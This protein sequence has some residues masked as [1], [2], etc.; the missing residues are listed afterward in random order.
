MSRFNIHRITP[1]LV[2]IRLMTLA[3]I[4]TTG[5]TLASTAD[6]R[7]FE[8]LQGPFASGPEVTKACISCHNKAAGEVQDSIH[9]SWEFNHPVTGQ[10]LGKRTVINS[11]C[12]NVVSN[13]PRCTSCH[14]SYDWRDM[15]QDPPSA[16]DDSKV[17]C[18]VCHD[19]TGD[20]SKWPTG[21]GHPLYKET[22]QKGKTYLPPDLTQVAQNVGMPGRENCGACHFYGGGG[23]NVKHGDLSSALVEATADVDIHMNKDG[24][25]FSCSTCHVA[26]DHKW[27]GSHYSMMATDPEGTGKPGERRNSASCESCHGLE[28]HPKTSIN[29]LKLNHHVES[30]AC[31]TCHIP[32]FAKGGV[33]TKTFWDW[34]QV[35]K[36]GKKGEGIED[37]VQGDGKHRHGYLKHKGVFKYGENVQPHYAWFNGQIEY[38]NADRKIDPNKVVEVNMIHGSEDDPDSRIWPFKRMQGRQA[39][40]KVNNNLVYT[41]VWG[42]TTETA[43]WTNFDWQKS[44]TAAMEKASKPYSGEFGF[45]DT[46]M[47]WPTTHMVAAKDKA[48]ACQECH[49]KEGRLKDVDITYMPASGKTQLIDLLSLLAIAATVL[50]I[51][52][53][54]LIRVFSTIRRKN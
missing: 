33:A 31:E 11:F 35:D 16:T 46:Y 18:L 50:G 9:G 34:S 38:S 44:I 32:E 19:T 41:N 20:Y 23:D 12:G 39:Y 13:E 42:P 49:A 43:L 26:A 51:F 1:Q 30:V 37:Y 2:I 24:L 53:H 25:D 4:I 5:H 27:A 52:G 14:A 47:Y 54:A 45:V 29:G 6:H 3:L 17:D 15:A 48:V 10:K 40:D 8:E 28:P 22:T 21:A 36:T 7:E